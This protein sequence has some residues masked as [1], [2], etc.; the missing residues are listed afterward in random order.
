MSVPKTSFVP[1][2]LKHICP[3]YQKAGLFLTEV[4]NIKFS[5][6]NITVQRTKGVT[7]QIS[8]LIARLEVLTVVTMKIFK[9]SGML[10]CVHQQLPTFGEGGG[11]VPPP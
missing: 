1:L 11:V 6:T 2:I 3:P 5:I 9:S 7:L 4:D 8:M 10:H